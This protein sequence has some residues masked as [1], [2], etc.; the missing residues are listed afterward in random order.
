[1]NI[2][3][4]ISLYT[5]CSLVPTIGWLSFCLHF[6][7]QAPEPKR[8]IWRMFSLGIFAV[9]PVMLINGPLFVL[10]NRYFQ[11]PKLATIIILS[12]LVDALIEELAKYIALRRGIYLRSVFDE[13]RDG[14][15]YGMTVGTGFAF[16]ENILYAATR[17]SLIE[18]MGLIFLRAISS[19]FMHILAGGMIGYY[20]GLAKFQYKYK[21]KNKH[22]IVWGLFLTIIFHGLYNTVLR[23]ENV[24]CFFSIFLL[25]IGTYF[26]I[27][28]GLRRLAR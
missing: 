8:E 6:D 5:I 14:M 16:L 20:L 27:L 26:F 4:K 25:L 9:L 13:P 7:R 17:S 21:L 19:S 24:W 3:I 22:I 12:F 11:L 15:I 1:M 18:G 23:I 28:R 10:I 2:L